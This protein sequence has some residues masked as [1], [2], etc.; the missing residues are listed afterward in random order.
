MFK[1]YNNIR[2]AKKMH[3]SI[4]SAILKW[5]LHK[6]NN[7]N[8]KKVICQHQNTNIMHVITRK[9]LVLHVNA[10]KWKRCSKKKCCKQ[11]GQV[12][13]MGT[14]AKWP[15]QKH[16]EHH[17]T[18]SIQRRDRRNNYCLCFSDFSGFFYH[19]YHNT[20]VYLLNPPWHHGTA[21]ILHNYN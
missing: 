7:I 4:W 12:K 15:V 16:T 3:K 5:V 6:I 1:I 13:F 2:M 17:K 19:L 9:N 18:R 8:L 10:Y 21:I 20:S 11:S 14:M